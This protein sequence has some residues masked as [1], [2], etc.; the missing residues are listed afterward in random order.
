MAKDRER[1]LE[2][3]ASVWNELGVT[4]RERTVTLAS[5]GKVRVQELGEGPPMVF[6]H[7][8]SIAGASWAHL[9]AKLDGVTSIMVDRP[10]CGLS[11]PIVGGPLRELGSLKN[12]ADGFLVSLLDALK[13]DQAAVG[14]T[15]FGGFFAFRGAAAA[16]DRVTKLIEYSWSVGA[17][18]ESAP[19]SARIGGLPLMQE[20]VVRMP[21]SRGMVKAALKQFGMGRAIDS[22]KFNDVMLD[23]AH[24]VMAH[25]D[26]MANDIRSTPRLFTLKGQNDAVLFSDE[27][28][29]KVTMPVLLLWGADDPNGGTAIAREFAPRLPNAELVIVDGAQHAPWIDELEIC[30]RHT[31]EFLAG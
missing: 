21:M 22:G 12:Y 8:G 24:A 2:A 15:S 19:M 31:R 23:W 20:L 5:G 14:A 9:A 10:G 29:S 4:P 30:A 18:M 16:P 7:G 3:E 1:Y 17:P 28:L 25:T 6:I 27:L 13:L 26:T 11:D